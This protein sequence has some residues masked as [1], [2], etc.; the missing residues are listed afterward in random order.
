[1]SRPRVSGR[2]RDLAVSPDGQR[3]YCASAKGGVWYSGDAGATWAPV[4]GWAGRSVNAQGNGNMFSSGSLLV[5]FTAG[6]AATDVVLVGTGEPTP[7][8][9]ETNASAQGGM[10][11]LAALGPTADPI[12]SDPW[13]PDTGAAVLAGLGVWRLVRHPAATA[14]SNA[15]PTQDRVLAAT[16]DGL[17]LGTRAP[18]PAVVAGPPPGPGLPAPTPLPPRDGY[19]WAPCAAAPPTGA[20]G[21]TDVTDV[22]WLAN[23]A[24]TRIVYAVAGVGVFVSNDSGA[25]AQPINALQAAAVAFN[26]RISLTL[27]PGTSRVYAL[28][29]V[30]VGGVPTPMLWQLT[31]VLATPQ[32]VVAVP[33]VPPNLFGDPTTPPTQASYDQGFAAE[34]VG[35]N[36]RLYLGG[37]AVYPRNDA[38]GDWSGS[39]YCFETPS[40]PAAVTPLAAAVGISRRTNPPT[41]DDADITG[42]IGNNVHPDIHAIRLTGA[43]AP[44]RSV[45]IGCDGGVFVSEHSGRV[46]T[47]AA[48]NSGLATLEPIFLANHPTSSHFVVAGLQDNGS[49][50]RVGDTVW[51]ETFE[52]DGGGTVLHPI[53]SDIMVGQWTAGYWNGA[54]ASD[55]VDPLVRQPGHPNSL[56][57]AFGRE[58]GTAAFYSGA[59][60]IADTAA[61]GRLA[62]GTNRTW[63]IDN[64]G[65]G[66]PARWR[67]LPHP[68]GTQR[69]T[70]PSGGDPAAQQNF[71]VPGIV[72][73]AI[74][75]ADQVI[76]MVWQSPNDLLVLYRSYLVRYT[77]TNKV[78]GTWTSKTWAPATI[79]GLPGYVLP[80]PLPANA[81]VTSVATVPG[82]L[83][84]YLTLLGDPA[85]TAA[86]TLWFYDDTASTF[87][88]TGFR[89]VLDFAG[90]PVVA[91]PRDPCFAAVVDPANIADVYVG[92]A[93][94]VWKGHRAGAAWAFVPFMNGL[95]QVTVQDLR[96]WQDPAGAAASPAT[97]ARRVQSRG[98][99][100]VDL[101][102]PQPRHTY[103]RVHERDDRRMFPTPMANPRRRPG[104]PAEPVFASPDITIRPAWPQAAPP[105]FHSTIQ[106]GNL[107]VYDLW[108]FQTA[109]RWLYPSCVPDGRWSDAMRD[110]V[111]FHRSVLGLPPGALIDSLLWRH[112]VGG[113]VS[114]V[115]RGIRLLPDPVFSEKATVTSNPADSLAVYT[116]P[117]QTTLNFSGVASEIDLIESVLPV[118][119]KSDEWTVFR[120]PS[121]VDILLHH[122][123]SRP[124]QPP[125]AFAVLLWRSA[126]TAA[127]LLATGFAD[128]PPFLAA[129]ALAG[130]GAPAPASPAGWNVATTAGGSAMR[131]LPVMLDARLPRAVSIDVDLST[132]TNGQRVLLLALVGSGAD[133]PVTAPAGAPANVADLVQAW[134]NAALRIVKVV[135]RV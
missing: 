14:L 26:G 11:V 2:I 132:V 5:D 60:A 69:D 65:S 131:T 54:P 66:T 126:A 9:S 124:V 130:V 35:A 61:T 27:V 46:N 128:L 59:A 48:R 3:A 6:M 64:L 32:T 18:L 74:P 84:F 10:G 13:E 57:A 135:N 8:Q 98:V 62:L 99:W 110:L 87:S 19:T 107:P 125:G 31:D 17:Y 103:V 94:G 123:D 15:G 106:T 111:R 104:A 68:A 71:G 37:S 50:V 44:T 33:G 58:N 117:W 109:L 51:E 101:A 45:W 120:E 96:I 78:A 115:Q 30:A 92:T 121:T 97:A 40:P 63:V 22:I 102:H 42:L 80:A 79:A 116:A 89:R 41:G 112:V 34:V 134:P 47:F 133:D 127:A 56:L 52:G 28:A 24:T 75:A 43:A 29:E 113:T 93:T 129:V 72:N 105:P 39:L 20:A 49:Q 55:F 7:W 16:T 53:R 36:D 88:P 86:E 76:D 114:G 90:P 95:P 100:E 82:T 91:G 12:D 77:N 119:S 73:P 25:T 108:T 1:M 81:S 83:D 67:T 21:A 38:E 118:A 23:G 4:G 122:R 70:R 85:N